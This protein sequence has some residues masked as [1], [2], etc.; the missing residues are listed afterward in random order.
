MNRIEN[1]DE[2]VTLFKSKLATINF[3]FLSEWVIITGKMFILF[4]YQVLT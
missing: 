2:W 4:N 3:L 1:D